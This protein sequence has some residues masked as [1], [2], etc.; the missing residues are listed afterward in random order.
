MS[1]GLKEISAIRKKGLRMT[2]CA[3][4]SSLHRGHQPG[5]FG[6]LLGMLFV[7]KKGNYL[8]RL[9]SQNN[10]PTQCVYCF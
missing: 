5:R 8:A 2:V 6:A 9:E 1:E 4:E 3:N 7:R 10:N